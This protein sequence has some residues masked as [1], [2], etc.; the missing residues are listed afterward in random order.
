LGGRARVK[1]RLAMPTR[2]PAFTPGFEE[3]EARRPLAMALSMPAPTTGLPAEVTDITDPRMIRQ[4]DADYLF[5]SGPGIPIHRSTDLIHWNEVGQVFAAMPA[6]A[7]AWVPGATAIWAPDISYFGGQYHLYYAVSTFGSQRS[8]I[9][10]ATSPTLDPNEPGYGWVDRGAV[11]ASS[12]RRTDYNAIDPNVVIDDRGQVWLAFGSQW[13]GIKLV[14]IDPAT[15]KPPQAH[16][17]LHALA[18]RPGSKPVEAPFLFERDGLYYLFASFGTCCMG[19][20][21]TYRIM[22][23]RSPSVTGP[24]VDRKGRPMSEG[25]GTLVLGSNAR[26]R[27]P[28]HNAVFATASGDDL[29]YHTY[30]ASNDGTATLQIRSLSWTDDGWPVAGATL[31]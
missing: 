11:I 13:S 27:G 30:D 22:V 18:S 24:Y 21:S 7:R 31:F 26:Y 29:V 6:W 15:G 12:P 3:L 17:R 9:G 1:S 14:R 20:A 19:S 5:S 16:P 4:G 23:G 10:L 25:G 28:G 8:V 2:T